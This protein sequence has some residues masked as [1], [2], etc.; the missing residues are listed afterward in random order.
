MSEAVLIVNPSS[1]NERAKDLAESVEEKL[2]GVYDKVTVKFTEKGGDAT[3]FAKN[4][5][6]KLVTAVFIMGGDGTVN[7]GINGLAEQVY[8][9]D[10]SFIPLGTVNDLARALG[11][12]M[13]PEEAIGQLDSL[14]KKKL[15]I[16]K[17][18]ESY[19]ANVVA[20]GTIPK[21]VQEVDV[22]QKT[23][24]G[25]LAY[26]L[27]GTKSFNSNEAYTFE[28]ELDEEK[29]S[30][31]SILVL[32]ALTNSVGGFEKLLPKAKIDDGY[33][34]LVALKG[35]TIVD[36]LKVIPKIFTGKATDDEKVLYRK[37][38]TGTIQVQEAKELVAN[39]DGDKGDS[40]PLTLQVLPQHLTVLVP[41]S[42][43][44]NS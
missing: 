31:E 18:N 23:K 43:N 26:F 37:F 16:G 41:R 8:R 5:A 28:L 20:I 39:V 42:S 40:L 24:L 36:K 19:F 11:I 44:N 10:F 4:A 14:E 12:P 38:K 1:G 6:E 30:Q 17:I 13:D 15:D 25:P 27:E 9:P 34:H 35:N 3:T 22:E 2:A 7:E 33:L 29:I 21:A 32:V